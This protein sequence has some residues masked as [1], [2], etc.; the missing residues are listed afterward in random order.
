MISLVILFLAVTTLISATEENCEIISADTPDI[1]SNKI[2]M[3]LSSTANAHGELA[4][5]GNYDY[6][7][8]CD[9]SGSLT[10]DGQN[11]IIGLSSETNAHAEIPDGT[12]YS[13]EVCYSDLSCRS[14]S[15]CNS[16]EISMLSLSSNSNAH[17]GGIN[18]YDIK[19]CCQIEEDEDNDDEN[20]NDGGGSS[21][22][23]SR[24][25]MN[26][27]FPTLISSPT[28]SISVPLSIIDIDKEVEKPTNS[29]IWF[30]ILEALIILIIILFLLRRIFVKRKK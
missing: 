13:F 18:D 11:K 30:L 2:I 22:K 12:T 27:N 23:R 20:D 4:S 6:I 17:I 7:L 16:N 14:S 29:L 1:D 19:I 15:S 26:L 25:T 24:R 9:F 10:C 5:E 3:A 21:S 8:Y 28:S